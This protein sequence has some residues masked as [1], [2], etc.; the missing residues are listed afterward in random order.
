MMARKLLAFA[1]LFW[2][3]P[4]LLQASTPRDPYQF[5]FEQSLGDLSEELEIAREEGKQGVFLFFEMDECPFCHRMKQ[6]VL[7]QPEVQEYFK[8]HFHSL[9]IDVEGDIDIVDF[10]GSDT[11]Q[12]EFAR[13][14]RVR[15][16][17]LLAL[18][19]RTV[20]RGG[21]HLD[22]RIHRRPGL[23]AKRRLGGQNPLYAL[24]KNEEE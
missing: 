9:S 3:V 15:A 6:T 4:A 22:G 12:K 7:N 20:G 16:T 13:Q 2:A 11:T 10:E 24:Q 8:Q 21:V 14:N 19:G 1:I 17:P 18:R 23:P 5:F